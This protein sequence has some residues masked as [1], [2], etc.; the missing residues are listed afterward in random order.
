MSG[1]LEA[2]QANATG[3]SAQPSAGQ[4][5][6]QAREA[7]GLHVAAL[8]GA[9]KVPVHK[10]EALEA[11]DYAAFSD[12]VFMRALASS[13]CRT[14][15][16]DPQPVLDQLPRSAIKGFDAQRMHLNA[17]IKARAGKS[18][19]M[20]SN[21]GGGVSRKAVLGVVV[22][23]LA[24]G[25][26]YFMPSGMLD[27]QDAGSSTTLTSQPVEVVPAP[28]AALP[29]TSAG[30]VPAAAALPG[31]PAGMPPVPAPAPA[32]AETPAPA[33]APASPPAAAVPAP[34][35]VAG[36]E[37]LVFH[38]TG[39]SWVQVTDARGKVVFSKNLGA[40]ETAQV[41]AQLP[42][43]V[44][45]GRAAVATL[46]VRGQAF[47]IAAAAPGKDVARFEVK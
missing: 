26:V 8:A 3:A 38:T 39:A 34:A 24:A 16:L 14:L 27:R 36:Q 45:V 30:D 13:I 5:L 6:R 23:L 21:G 28:A 47:D 9:L 10:L 2:Q 17:P 4:R 7:A 1:V 41:A 25:A 35:L 40:G 18:G 22:L 32:A 37:S 20:A 46:Q 19:G 11:D 44:V 31:E 29:A 42:A 12:H 33:A 15:G 43:Q